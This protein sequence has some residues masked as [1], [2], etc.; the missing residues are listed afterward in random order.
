MTDLIFDGPNSAISVT[1][2]DLAISNN[3]TITGTLSATTFSGVTSGTSWVS[4]IQSD[5]F[6]A[7]SGKGYF[8]DTST[9]NGAITVTLP[10]SPS[11]GDFVAVKD[12]AANFDTNNCTIARNSSNIDGDAADA[13]LSVQSY[14]VTFVYM[15]DTKGWTAT[16]E[17]N[18]RYGAAFVEATGGTV[19]TDGDFKVH[20]FT[21]DG[22]FT[23]T[24]AGNNAGSNSVDY[25]V[26]AGGGSGGSGE[27]LNGGGEAAGGGGAG[28]YR[29]SFPNP[30]SGG[31]PVSE[32]AYPITVGAGATGAAITNSPTGNFGS[33]GSNSIFSTIT[34]TGGGGGATENGPPYSR[35]PEGP[36][37]SGGGGVFGPGPNR[38]VGFGNTPPVSPPQG[39]DGGDGADAGGGGGGAGAAGSD[40]QSPTVGGAGG[41][42]ATSSINGTSTVR[43]SG[44]SGGS[45]AGGAGV[46]ATPGGGGQSNSSFPNGSNGPRTTDLDATA[47]TGG[48]GGASSS[49]VNSTP[50]NKSGAGGSGIVIIRY[51]FQ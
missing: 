4:D 3:T 48:G 40:K 12:Y 8:V 35:N 10:A 38:N 47:N 13:T 33:R 18:T 20:T 41:A 28:G 1:S 43:A 17:N 39:N 36:G 27:G 32:Q 50:N 49:G 31:L 45:K 7:E 44:G 46:A 11:S 29:E 15:D 24:A 30:G 19:T 37:G 6:T 22:T 34:S 51:K 21:A 25:L 26:I 42:G 9:S 23:V 14:G 16:A 2:G 5:D